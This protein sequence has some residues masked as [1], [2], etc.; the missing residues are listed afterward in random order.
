MTADPSGAAVDGL[1]RHAAQ[2]STEARARIEKAL[3]A[4]RKEQQPIN[5]NAVARRAGVTRKT[6][7]HHTDLAERIRALATGRPAP[8][9]TPVPEG[10]G[11]VIAALRRQLREQQTR[12]T[13]QVRQLKAE[14]KQREQALAAAHG[15]IQRL[16]ASRP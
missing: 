5:I 9:V 2:R 3:R 12:H 4:L 13:E 10:Q 6:I 11:S 14:L 8:A 15:E 7:Y 16:T 1:R